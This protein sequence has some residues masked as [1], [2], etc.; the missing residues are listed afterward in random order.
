M[1]IATLFTFGLVLFPRATRFMASILAAV[2]ISDSLQFAYARLRATE[3][4]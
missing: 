1:W 2:T 4:S 3:E